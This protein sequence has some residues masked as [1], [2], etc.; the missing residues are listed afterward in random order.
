MTRLIDVWLK[1]D[2]RHCRAIARLLASL[3]LLIGIPWYSTANLAAG[4]TSDRFSVRQGPS[5][6]AKLA[7]D[8]GRQAGEILLAPHSLSAPLQPFLNIVP[9][10]KGTDL[11]ISAGGVGQLGGNVFA[12]INTGPSGHKDSWTMTYSDTAEVYVTTVTGFDP[13]VGAS[14]TLDIT[15][16]GGLATPT[17]GFARARV[18]PATT[19]TLVS[20][21]GRLRLAAVSPDTFES[22]TYIA[23]V[24]SFAPRAAAPSGHRFVGSTYSVRASGNLLASRRPMFLEISLDDAALAGADRHTLAL[25]AWDE[26]AGRWDNLG[27]Q[28]LYDQVANSWSVG[29]ATTRFS[30]YAL[31]ATPAWVDEFDDPELGGLAERSNLEQG[32]LGDNLALILSNRPGSGMA[33]SPPISPTTTFI[34]WDSL[35]FTGAFSSPTTTLTIDILSVTGTVVLSNVTSGASLAGIDPTRYSALKLRVSLNSTTVNA[36]PALDSWR[37]A[38]RADADTPRLMI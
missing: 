31:M 19:P 24:P 18:M 14:G 20:T 23:I 33:I 9:A 21:D 38:W 27:G 22:L 7:G 32:P 16:T 11:F 8:Q 30:T 37:L 10:S 34:G 25:F 3:V 4:S 5:A 17:V 29:V 35:S 15:T 26:G 28:L 12:N 6:G 2:I 13:N 36:T 1:S